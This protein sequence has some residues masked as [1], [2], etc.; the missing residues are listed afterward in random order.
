MA[1]SRYRLRPLVRLD[2]LL[3]RVVDWT[4]EAYILKINK[5]ALL[6]SSLKCLI[7]KSAKGR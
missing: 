3:G 1:T 5:I 2:R 4:I 7:Y 6:Y